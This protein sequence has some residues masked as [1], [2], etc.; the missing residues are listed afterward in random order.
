MA[1]LLVVE[2][3]ASIRTLLSTYLE[4]VG[5]AVSLAEDGLSGYAAVQDGD[6]DLVLMDVMMPRIDG[7]TVVELIR[8]DSDVPIIVVSA[9]SEVDD[10][11]RA[12]DLLVDDFIPKPFDVKIV[13]KRVDAVLRRREAAA[14]P[15]PGATAGAP[16]PSPALLAHADLTLDPERVEVRVGGIPVDLTKREFDLLHLLIA[17]PGRVFSREHLLDEVWGHRYVG[18]TKVVNAHVQNLRKKVGAERIEAVRGM[19]YRLA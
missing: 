3:E 19:G 12:F 4:A 8:R 16:A 2:D 9:L 14:G 10:Q 5:H 7:L 17:N 11:V 18:N 1:R 6:F 15:V 13:A